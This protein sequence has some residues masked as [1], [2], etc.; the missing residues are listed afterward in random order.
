MRKTLC[1]APKWTSG[2]MDLPMYPN[3]TANDVSVYLR[4]S[5]A[6]IKR[7]L[8]EGIIPGFKIE[9]EWFIPRDKFLQEI[10]R[11]TSQFDS[12]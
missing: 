8:S 3:L 10:E 4:K 5:E 7:W 2:K 11:R 6:T 1:Y 12:K 9:R